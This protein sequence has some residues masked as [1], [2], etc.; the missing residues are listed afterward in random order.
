MVVVTVDT[1]DLS[2]VKHDTPDPV[3]AGE[4]LTYTVDVT[5][6]GPSAATSVEVTDT[7]P[8]ATAFVSASGTGWTCSE[9]GGTVTCGRDSL[10]VDET[11]RIAIE[12]TAPSQAGR[13]ANT[14]SVTAAEPDPDASSNQATVET[15]VINPRIGIAKSAG[16]P[17]VNGDG[18]FDVVFTFTLE[19]LGGMD[20]SNVQATDDLSA[21]FPPPA[22]F[23][24]AVAPT[25]TGTL[26][27]NGAFDG[28]ANA[29]TTEKPVGNHAS[30]KQK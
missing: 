21:N 14:V 19:N 27:A 23:T 12:V 22:T 25:A 7:L 3:K 29:T 4:T 2:I 15:D 16:P 24:V 20:L 11:S 30:I 26:T 5:N 6:N 13:I 10:A 18:T 1:S 17:T 8:A 28:S 9:A